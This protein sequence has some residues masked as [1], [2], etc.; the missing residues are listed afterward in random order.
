[1]LLSYLIVLAARVMVFTKSSHRQW[2]PE[3][4]SIFIVDLDSFQLTLIR[5]FQKNLC[6]DFEPEH[7]PFEYRLV[8][9]FDDC[10][11]DKTF[12]HSSI[13]QDLMCNSRH[14][15]ITLVF[16]IKS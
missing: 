7:I 15:G 13:V 8:I 5:D 14:Y 2:R 9:A 16:L 3:I 12:M 1:M 6:K 10:G 4:N 11:S